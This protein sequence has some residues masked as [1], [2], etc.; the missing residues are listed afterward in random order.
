MAVH[1][2]TGCRLYIGPVAG[3]SV[4]T[5]AE[6]EALSYTE[7]SQIQDLGEFGDTAEELTF[8]V[9]HDE[10][11]QSRKGSVDGGILPLVLSYDL[12]DAGQ[13]ALKAASVSRSNYAFKILFGGD[14][15]VEA[16]YFRGLVLSFRKEIGGADNVLSVASD[17]AIN[18]AIVAATDALTVDSTEETVDSDLI[19]VDAG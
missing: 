2:S 18:S 4:D 14:E 11:L 5:E 15:P 17:I 8:E 9:I 16:F 12:G 6:F 13:A 19:I 3:A 7:I 10:R 1:T